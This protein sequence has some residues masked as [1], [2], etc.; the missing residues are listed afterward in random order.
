LRRHLLA[1]ISFFDFSKVFCFSGFLSSLRFGFF[2]RWARLPFRGGLIFSFFF[3]IS[4]YHGRPGSVSA[5]LA[6]SPQ[7][8]S[9]PLLPPYFNGPSPPAADMSRYRY[10][11][12]SPAPPWWCFSE[13]V[14]ELFFFYIP[15]FFFF[16]FFTL[17]A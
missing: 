10:S 14:G 8:P 12:L 15:L 6:V 5:T 17:A 3:D 11:N 7:N 2:L 1:R 13:T 9:G 16:G 4:Y